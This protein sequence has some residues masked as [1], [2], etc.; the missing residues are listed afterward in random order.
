MTTDASLPVYCIDT[1]AIG[2][3]EGISPATSYT[4]DTAVR[5]RVWGGLESMA[6]AGR[7]VTVYAAQDEFKRKCPAAHDRLG[8]LKFFRRDTVALFVEAQNVL[9][10]S[11]YWQREVQRCKPN[12]D[13][14]DYYLVALA[15]VE[16]RTVVTS[17]LHRRDRS[18]NNRS[19]D[20]IPDVC[21]RMDVQWLYL[22]DFIECER[23]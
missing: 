13:K 20:N 12:R 8:P 1:S 23:L 18:A 19:G 5:V 4:N 7:L 10:Q 22:S 3:L 17:E 9:A 16:G 15:R 14:A 2:D 11:E 21:D 6:R